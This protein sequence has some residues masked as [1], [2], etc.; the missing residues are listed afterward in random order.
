MTFNCPHCSKPYAKKSV[1]YDEHILK[2]KKNPTLVNKKKYKRKSINSN[3]RKRVWERYIGQKT[4]AKCF[5][6]WENE[7]TPFT[8]C[9]TFHAGHIKSHANGGLDTIENLLPINNHHHY[10]ILH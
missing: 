9:N 8:Y 1:W 5:C 4:S 10:Y 3:L 2:C 6:C 7:I